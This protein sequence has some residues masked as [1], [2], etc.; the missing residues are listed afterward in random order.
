MKR[1]ALELVWLARL[2][3]TGCG[4]TITGIA[5]SG[6]VTRDGKPV[7]GATILFVPKK[8]TKGQPI[9]GKITD[10]SDRLAAQEGLQAGQY[11]LEISLTGVPIK[12]QDFVPKLDQP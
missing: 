3:C 11:A 10:G 8:G 4:E 6:T 5:V 12:E 1:P 7:D 2:V 9:R